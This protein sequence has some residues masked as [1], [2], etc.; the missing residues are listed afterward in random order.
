MTGLGRRSGEKLNGGEEVE[1]GQVADFEA[2]LGGEFLA[3]DQ[4]R[5]DLTRAN[6]LADRV[7]RA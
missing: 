3:E 1:L 7:Q 6:S 5:L 2:R 4:H